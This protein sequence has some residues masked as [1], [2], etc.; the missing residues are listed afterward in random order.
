MGNVNET[1]RETLWLDIAKSI[2]ESLVRIRKMSVRTIWWGQS[3]S[4]QKKKPQTS[5]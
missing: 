3:L 5:N 4:K 1:F 2:A